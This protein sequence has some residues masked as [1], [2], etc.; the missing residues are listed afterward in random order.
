[1]VAG[2]A[3]LVIED[4]ARDPRFAHNPFLRK[5]GLRFYAGVP[6]RTRSEHVIGTLCVMDLKPRT[7]SPRELKLMQ[8]I[9]DELMTDLVQG[10]DMAIDTQELDTVAENA[11]AVAP[12]TSPNS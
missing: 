6:L 5:H 7:L 8:V 3:P 11:S 9:A 12:D 1:V 10:A 2:N 4:T